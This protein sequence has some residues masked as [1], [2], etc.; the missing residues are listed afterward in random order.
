MPYCQTRHE[1][2]TE[3]VILNYMEHHRN[4]LGKILVDYVVLERKDFLEYVQG[5]GNLN[6]LGKFY[7]QDTLSNFLR[8]TKTM[9]YAHNCGT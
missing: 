3:G 5:F 4:V 8:E 6:C 1:G 9:F 7:F 2:T